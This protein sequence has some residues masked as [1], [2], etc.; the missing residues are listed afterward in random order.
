VKYTYT[1][2]DCT[3]EHTKTWTYTYF[4]KDTVKPAITNTLQDLTV[5]GCNR[6]VMPA[7]YTTV[8]ELTTQG[9]LIISDNCT[10]ATEL[11]LSSRDV[12]TDSACVITVTRYYTV[13]DAC[14]NDSTVSQIIKIHRSDDFTITGVT[15]SRTVQCVSA[16]RVEDITLPVVKDA[17]NVTL[18]P[19]DTTVVNNIV[20]C[21]G[22]VKY[23]FRYQN[24]AEK[25][26]AWT[27]TYTVDLSPL[28][29]PD[30]KRDTI[31]CLTDTNTRTY[32]PPV[33]KNICDDVANIFEVIRVSTVGADNKGAI[34]HTYRYAVCADTVEWSHVYQVI[35]GSF[36]PIEDSVKNVFC[37][38]DVVTPQTPEFVVC[39]ETVPVEYDS[40][41]NAVA[42]CDT[43][44]Y[45]YHYTVNGTK[46]VWRY[47]Y[48]VTPKAFD[49][50]ASVTKKVQCIAD[51]TR[52]TPPMVTN[53]CGDPIVPTLMPVDSTEHGCADTVKY[54]YT[55]NDCTLEHIKTWTYTYFVK[56]TVKPAF[57][58]PTDLT[59]CRKLDGSYEVDPV[60]LGK[61]TAMSDNCR[62]T[63]SLTAT[64]TDVT[65][66]YTT[67]QDTITRTW[68]VSDGCNDSLRV[69]RIFINPVKRVSLSDEI[70]ADSTYNKFG[71]NFVAHADTIVH[72]TTASA[73]TGCDSVTTVTIK[74]YQQ[75]SATITIAVNQSELPYTINGVTYN[76]SGT[77]T[78]HLANSHNCD[79]TL[80]VTIQVTD[81][82][83]EVDSTVCVTDL[84]VTWNDSIF[85]AAGTKVTT[86][87]TPTG[88]DSVL[89]MNLYVR[90]LANITTNPLSVCPTIGDV[91][92]TAGF[93]PVLDN[94]STVTWSFYG[95]TATHTDVVIPGHTTD[96]YSA[97]IPSNLCDSLIPYVVTYTDEY[98]TTIDTNYVHV[99]DTTAPKITG[100]LAAMELTGCNRTVV[101]AAATTVSAL[102]TLGLTITENCTALA[103]LAVTS[104]DERVDS[105]CVITVK[106][107]YTLSDACGNRST[108]VQ[109]ITIHRDDF[110]VPADGSADVTCINDVE[111]DDIPMP[112]V[113]DACG[114][115]L[116]PSTPVV[117]ETG[118]NGCEGDVV[119]TFTYTDCAEHAH[120]WS[121]TFHIER[122]DYITGVPAPGSA[123]RMCVVD[124]KRPTAPRTIDDAC[125]EP[126]VPTFVDSIINVN[127]DEEGT[128]TY[129]FKY[130]D[131]AGN[132]SMW[133]FIYNIYPDFH[134]DPNDTVYVN[135]VSEVIGSNV[136]NIVECEIPI[137]MRLDSI[138]GTD[139][140]DGCGDTTFIYKYTVHNQEYIWKNTYRVI[141]PDFELPEDSTAL[142]MCTSD[143]DPVSPVVLNACGDTIKAVMQ[144]PQITFDGCEGRAV[145]TFLYTDCS[146]ETKDWKLTYTIRDTVA[147]LISAPENTSV[148]R[149]AQG[150]YNAD[151]NITGRPTDYG[152]NCVAPDHLTVEFTETVTTHLTT[153]D[154]ITRIWTVTDSCLNTAKDTQLIVIYPTTFGIDE[155][156]ACD[157]LKWE[158]NN[159]VYRSST[160]EPTVVLHGAN[161]YGCD[162][163]VTL[164][165]TINTSY[166]Q[167]E[168]LTLC[169][170]DLPYVL[171]Q[172]GGYVIERGTASSEIEFEYTSVQHC[173]SIITLHLTVNP[174]Y[175]TYDTVRYCQDG[176]TFTYPY[177]E[178]VTITETGVTSTSADIVVENTAS[179]EDYVLKM[180]T[181]KACDSILYLHTDIRMMKRDTVLK[182]TMF[183]DEPF[184]ITLAGHDFYVD[185]PD[186]YF[187]TD[188]NAAANGCDSIMLIR[189]RVRQ[190]CDLEMQVVAKNNPLCGED[191]NFTVSV[192]GGYAP[193]RYSIND[194]MTWQNSGTFDSLSSGTYNVVAIDKHN[195]YVETTVE[196]VG[197]G[198]PEVTII[199]P[200]DYYDTLAYGDCV[201]DIYPERIGMPTAVHSLDWPMEISN[202]LPASMLFQEGEH[203]VQWVAV[204]Q[205]GVSDTCEQKIF[206]VFPQCPDAVDCEGHVYHSVRIDC[207]CWTQR[208]LESTKYKDANG[209][210]NVEIPCDYIYSS[211]QYPETAE[212]LAIY[213]RLY[214]YEAVIRDS[215]VNEYGHI[216]GICPD[217]WYLPTPDQYNQLNSHGPAQLRYNDYWLDGGGNNETEFSALPAGFFNGWN[218]RFEG[219]GTETYFWATEFVTS[220]IHT[221]GQE[222]ESHI[223][224]SVIQ[225]LQTDCDHV[226][227]SDDFNGSA[228]S[229]RCIKEK[230]PHNW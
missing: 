144:Q 178:Y 211:R 24:C 113:T 161:I 187:Y 25:D 96:I 19:K 163:V 225:V 221:S 21:E 34:T 35:P 98:C 195:C 80:I 81:V 10:N 141:P 94:H 114:N 41:H 194:G 153:P 124:A 173:D 142:V 206:I 170:Q 150:L 218:N 199:C 219:M 139:L 129:R 40:T 27:F 14:G 121:Y 23:T 172:H 8:A 29:V 38:T 213:G 42:S 149:N 157:S 11:T 47:I 68:R 167:D 70:C 127:D 222:E 175:K 60:A 53:S 224:T 62:A 54:T 7:A 186:V 108:I 118:Y 5:E 22:T 31:A 181:V 174:S 143:L 85:T 61:P 155:H 88:A 13:T 37:L 216:Q 132:D 16:A 165:L 72:D 9:G 151:T 140:S 171:T 66:S 4:V 205:C 203:T 229:V 20:N 115:T 104:A 76:A 33:I 123:N 204:D 227:E 36:T 223:H 220:H 158:L 65:T 128:V 67:K 208:N 182:D 125:G 83:N 84:P 214:C 77:Y 63:E 226:I 198:I 110:T 201:M 50:P 191:G 30:I 179:S 109:N 59:I 56:D 154:T 79:S 17:C 3:L 134:P 101:P 230:E 28:A 43:A 145:Y 180:K 192:P 46:Y 106:R 176:S 210:C 228:F 82:Y 105:G 12:V 92:L 91:E 196:L 131:C 90:E 185:R 52:P 168:Y 75:T 93:N 126:I 45:Y 189:L 160:D 112:T 136:L 146:G 184:T 58:A 193:I 44:I 188:T 164:H 120:N 190:L 107:T 152:D 71:F 73:I 51:V 130:S 1:Y 95:N 156:V 39:G 202:D 215:T 119:Y 32:T 100:T 169:Q 78:Q 177:N 162:S 137:E 18:T 15:D 103:D 212:N 209:E 200:R 49:V 99:V 111:E 26:T 133:V 217:G 138:A 122:S 74:V 102:Q 147:P 159:Q 2:N 117:D 166:H 87:L 55:Y 183:L 197:S 89:T 64:Y 207:E 48:S 86:L 69:Q 6:S 148:C 116:T 135:C 97:Q 57:T